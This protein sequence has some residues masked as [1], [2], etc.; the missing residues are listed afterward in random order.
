MVEMAEP[1]ATQM[2]SKLGLPTDPELLVRINSGVHVGAGIL[3]AIGK[4]RRLAA[5]ALFGTLIPTTWA[6]HRWWEEKDEAARAQ[7]QAHFYKNLGLM[8]GLVLA[9]VDTEG[10]PSLGWRAKRRAKQAGTAIAVGSKAASGGKEAGAKGGK[11]AKK[12]AKLGKHAAKA[13]TKAAAARQ[14]ATVRGSA[15]ADKA[16]AKAEAARDKA[17][18][19]ADKAASKADKAA[20][21]AARL[22]AKGKSAVI[23]AGGKAAK[24]GAKGALVT[25]AAGAV[26]D[27]AR[28]TLQKVA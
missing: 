25:K 27:T 24:A 22:A 5:L 2:A 9:A 3:L 7:Q 10:A 26:A 8:G 11:A 20:S 28:G 6:A 13:A 4:F 21:K 1:Q 19:K 16:A 12:A 14:L 15:A 18:A 17:S 23:E